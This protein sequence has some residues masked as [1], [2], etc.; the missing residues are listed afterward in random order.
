MLPFFNS[1][2]GETAKRTPQSLGD[3]TAA[4]ANSTVFDEQDTPLKFWLPVPVFDALGKLAEQHGASNSAWLRGF[5][6]THC[7]GTYV[8]TE[9]LRSRPKLFDEYSDGVLYSRAVRRTPEGYRSQTSYFVP[10]LGKNIAPVK[11]WIARTVNEDLASL[12]AHVGVSRSQYCR[13][14]LTARLLGHGTLPMRPSLLN[15]APAVSLSEWESEDGK[16]LVYTEVTEAE[17]SANGRFGHAETVDVVDD[18]FD[19]S[20][21]TIPSSSTTQPSRR[22]LWKKILG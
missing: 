6:A 19:P 15:A 18:T 8:V 14:M 20:V 9:L 13:E 4:F 17:F 5:L 22:S 7:Y 11:V 2:R 16:E 12:A 21:S 1:K 10:E 3:L